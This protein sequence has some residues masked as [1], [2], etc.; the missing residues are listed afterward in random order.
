MASNAET[1][2]QA[3]IEVND[4]RID[5]SA[6]LLGQPGDVLQKQGE[7]IFSNFYTGAYSPHTSFLSLCTQ[8]NP[9]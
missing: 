6:P 2:A 4:D 7:S 9:V 3:P 1:P 8:S 5:E